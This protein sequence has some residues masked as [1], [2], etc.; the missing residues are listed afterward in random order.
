MTQQ[1]TYFCAY[2]PYAF[3]EKAHP[4][5]LCYQGPF[6]QDIIS[7]MGHELRHSTASHGYASWKLFAVFV[8]LAQNIHFH[9]IERNQ[10]D[11]QKEPV[12]VILVEELAHSFQVTTA[13]LV[14]ATSVEKI[15][16]R[17]EAV[18][19]LSPRELRKYKNQLLSNAVEDNLTGGNIG[20]V[21]VVLLSQEQ[22]YFELKPINAEATLFVLTSVI[23]KGN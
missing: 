18:N 20:L 22:I 12:G 15:R 10:T 11:L 21:Q 19:Q 1:A 23:K 7:T 3:L 17:C 13:N 6:E 8:E 14:P 4:P 2:S 9:S 16:N 5:V